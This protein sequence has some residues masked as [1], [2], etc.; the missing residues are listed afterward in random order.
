MKFIVIALT[1]VLAMTAAEKLTTRQLIDL[2]R[3][4]PGAPGLLD[5]LKA[6]LN[7]RICW[8]AWPP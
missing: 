5:G 3:K 4:S 6:T 1:A 7:G 2:A 8:Q